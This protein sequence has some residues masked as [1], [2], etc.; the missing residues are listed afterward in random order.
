[1]T[2]H[3]R[4]SQTGSTGLRWVLTALVVATVAGAAGVAVFW[5]LDVGG[6][7]EHS[8]PILAIVVA[9]IAGAAVAGVTGRPIDASVVDLVF[10]VDNQQIAAIA[11][12]E[13]D[14]A[15]ELGGEQYL[16]ELATTTRALL[17]VPF[18]SFDIPPR[19]ETPDADQPV[20]LGPSTWSAHLTA[21]VG[22]APLGENLTRPVRVGSHE[23]G[24]ITVGTRSRGRGF[25]ADDVAA[26]DS[27]ARSAGLAISNARHADALHESRQR[28]VAGI[29]EE[30]RRLRRDLHDELG[31][32]LAAM[33]L[34]LSILRRSA[35]LPAVSSKLVDEIAA[36]VDTTTAGM[37]RLGHSNASI[38]AIL[39]YSPKTVR[40]YVSIILAKLCVDDRAR[41]IVVG[42]KAGV[43][44]RP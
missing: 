43:H 2:T 15:A 21:A 35:G 32:N 25:S 12:I 18:V 33:K 8:P 17:R 26:V 19:V 16:T 42:R 4:Q 9:V 39:G 34:C 28:L 30:R 14:H 6:L 31:P 38:A 36:T 24:A 23:I 40:N 7:A 10:G 29:E 27:I 37:R 20:A 5:L 3:V 11:G 13:H 1:M 41:A 22:V 44:R